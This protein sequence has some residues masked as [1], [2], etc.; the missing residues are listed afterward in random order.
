MNHEEMIRHEMAV[1]GLAIADIYP[2]PLGVANRY[3]ISTPEGDEN[4]YEAWFE[5]GIM[6]L[7][8]VIEPAGVG[9]NGFYANLLEK[10]IAAE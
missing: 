6:K 8:R 4:T 1:L 7:L 2:H 5:G 10:P 3:W 9:R